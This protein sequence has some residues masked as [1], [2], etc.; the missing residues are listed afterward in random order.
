MNGEWLSALLWSILTIIVEL[1]AVGFGY[2]YY[3]D[4]D[5]RKLMFTLA[6][7]FAALAYLQNIQPKWASIQI[8]EKSHTWA[9]IPVISALFIAS[10]SSFLRLKDF[11]KLFKAFLFILA[12]S[13]LMVVVPFPETSAHTFMSYGV[14]TI[15]LV[16]L[17][18]LILARRQIPDLMFLF[19]AIFFMLAGIGMAEN[20][21]LEFN[22]LTSFLGYVFI[23]FVFM[24]AK[25]DIEGGISSF[26]ALKEELEETQ[27]KLRIS[28]EQLLKAERLAAIGELAAMVG[29]DLRN[30]LTGIAGA[31]YYLKT[32]LGSEMDEKTREMFEVIEKDIE[33]SNQIVND[34]IEYSREIQLELTETTPKSITE[35]TLSLVKVPKNIRVRDLTNGKPKIKIDVEKMKRV[36]VNIIQ[37][38]IDAMSEGDELTITSNESRGNLEIAFAD[39]G[40]GMSKEILEKLWTPLFTTKAKGMGLGLSTCK[41]IVE[42]HGGNISVESAVGEGTIFTITIPIKPKINEGEK[43]WL[44]PSESSLS[45]TTKA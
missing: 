14:G 9:D 34:L 18:Y 35:E 28:Q 13:M 37:N 44:K 26:F 29:H 20:F 5:K 21:A 40:V 27:E 25:K 17:I 23:T 2:L 30:P 10:L 39:T 11:N 41:R 3:K 24:T 38:A 8:I 32:R 31:A 1:F 4:R 36:F 16:L 45:T 15:L 43:V 7:A 22:V 19:S 12:A 6:F 42:A 33:Y